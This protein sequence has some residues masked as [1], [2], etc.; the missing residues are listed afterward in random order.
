M[1]P[2][3]TAR[4]D[5]M[6]NGA[7]QSGNFIT[8]IPRNLANFFVVRPLRALDRGEV[9]QIAY[10][11]MLRAAAILVVVVGPIWML[12]YL[13]QDNGW[14]AGL[15]NQENFFILRSLAALPL[16]ALV[17]FATILIVFG[18]LWTRA[19]DL[20]EE[21][22]RGLIG[23]FLRMIKVTGEVYS[24]FP[25]ST[26]LTMFFA[27]LFAARPYTPL[28]PGIGSFTAMLSGFM[29][30][31]RPLSAMAA[32]GQGG[33]GAEITLSAWLSSIGG[34]L[35]GLIVSVFVSI[36]ILAFFYLLAEVLGLI[37]YFLLR[38]KMFEE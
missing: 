29:E 14:W 31:L 13:A 18:I 19:G 4:R 3:T 6:S 33:W 5:E 28:A 38:K 12:V 7:E 15:E 1:L 34:S 21:K 36:T 9:F 30:F 22:Y 26:A 37:Y 17:A 11:F 32:R 24:V 35:L 8:R 27:S 2:E 16:E 23:I 10:T 25:L 20:R